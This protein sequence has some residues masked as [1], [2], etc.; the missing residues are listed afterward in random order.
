MKE[1]SDP[2]SSDESWEVTR[3]LLTRCR[4]SPNGGAAERPGRFSRNNNMLCEGTA[5]LHKTIDN[6]ATNANGD[7]CFMGPIACQSSVEH[8]LANKDTP[9]TVLTTAPG[10]DNVRDVKKGTVR[11]LDRMRAAKKARPTSRLG[12]FTE[13]RMQCWM[14]TMNEVSPEDPLQ[15]SD[16]W[17]QENGDQRPKRVVGATIALDAAA[18]EHH[19]A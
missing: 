13:E 15:Q 2:S 10:R 4:I 11:M 7:L 18:L 3:E 17:I 14:M 6:Y 8:F 12:C 19:Q 9:G 5:T 1:E 16:P